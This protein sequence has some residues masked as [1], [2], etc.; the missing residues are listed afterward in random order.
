MRRRTALL[1]GAVLL[2]GVLAAG[3][4]GWYFDWGHAPVEKLPRLHGQTLEAVIA[5]LG[6][7]DRQLE[8]RLADSPGGEFRVELYNTYPPDDPKAAQARIKELQW[9]RARYRVA[10]WLHE[11]DGGWVVLDTCRWQQGVE[12]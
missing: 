4:L 7:P 3:A 10:V 6:P 9:R 12:F 8:Y 1:A 2:S 11:V 5:Q